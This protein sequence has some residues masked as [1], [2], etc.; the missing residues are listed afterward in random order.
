LFIIH[1]R[2]HTGKKPYQC[3]QCSKGFSVK[4]NLSNHMKIHTGE[5]PYQ[6]SQCDKLSH[7]IVLLLIIRGNTLERNHTTNADNVTRLSHG[8]VLLLIIRG[9]TLGRNHL[10]ADNV[11]NL[12]HGNMFL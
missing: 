2:T 10:N 3:N 1:Q 6:C 5:R 4:T 12:S 8:I 11:T 9:H 7:G